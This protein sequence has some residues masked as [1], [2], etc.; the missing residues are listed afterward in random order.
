MDSIAS[1]KTQ[2]G[3]LSTARLKKIHK[4]RQHRPAEEK[5][6]NGD[7]PPDSNSHHPNHSEPML[8]IEDME[9]DIHL[10]NELE[11]TLEKKMPYPL[12][13]RK[14]DAPEQGARINVTI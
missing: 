7:N 5:R 6:Q 8:S 2:S 14:V 9:E 10:R 4:D 3:I 1:Q 11:E 13:N 12:R